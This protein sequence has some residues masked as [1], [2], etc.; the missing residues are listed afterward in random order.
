[1]NCPSCDSIRLFER[2]LQNG[3]VIDSCP[4]CQG[5]WLD[6]G[7]LFR[8][9]RNKQEAREYVELLSW[10]SQTTERLCCRCESPMVVGAFAS[11]ETR[12]DYC[13]KCEGLWFDAS[14]LSKT[15]EFLDSCEQPMEPQRTA[16]NDYEQ[17]EAADE[18]ESIPISDMQADQPTTEFTVTGTDETGQTAFCK[19]AADS[20]Q[21]ALRIAETE[22]NLTSAT[23]IPDDQLSEPLPMGVSRMR[24]VKRPSR[25]N[26]D[27]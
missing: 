16:E 21:A 18:S 10:R 5:T 4:K 11:S 24:P 7:E 17:R 22:R 15:I 14:E 25:R 9:T 20:E 6:R 26:D 3:L 27:P 19:I 8:L 1:M 13:S 2:Q 23:I 12:L